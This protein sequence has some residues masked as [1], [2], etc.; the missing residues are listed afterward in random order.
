VIPCH[1][2]G[3]LQLQRE[4]GRPGQNLRPL[5]LST[6]LSPPQDS[7]FVTGEV[8]DRIHKILRNRNP[9]YPISL[10]R[11]FNIIFQSTTTSPY[12]FPSG[13]PTK[14]LYVVLLLDFIF[15]KTRF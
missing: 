9:V 14:T 5:D 7:H 6:E 2:R 15:L 10:R 4:T 3:L 8:H 1:V 12:L 11:V 13:F